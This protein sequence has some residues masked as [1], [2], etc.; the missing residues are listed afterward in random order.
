M[1]SQLLYKFVQ[2]GGGGNYSEQNAH[3]RKD[4]ITMDSSSTYFIMNE[5]VI[6]LTKETKHTSP[7]KVTSK[8]I[9]L[10]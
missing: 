6:R 3:E 4:T 9:P 10:H 1:I 7:I 8:Q 5:N 2:H